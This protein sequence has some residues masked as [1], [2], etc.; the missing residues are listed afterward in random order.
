M[1]LY[2]DV[3]ECAEGIHGCAEG[4]EECRNTEG[5]YECDVSCDPGF[6][7]STSLG[8]CVGKWEIF[9]VR[10]STVIPRSIFRHRRVCKGGFPPVP[11]PRIVLPK[12]YRKLRMC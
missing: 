5:A 3:D 11:Y 2:T 10:E 4:S 12:H 9:R 6:T 7:Y 1:I 8:I